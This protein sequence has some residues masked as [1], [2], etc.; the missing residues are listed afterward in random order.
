MKPACVIFSVELH[1][2]QPLRLAAIRE[3]RRKVTHFPC[4]GDAAGYAVPQARGVDRHRFLT[5]P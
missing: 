1:K 4:L 2:M 5:V 3:S